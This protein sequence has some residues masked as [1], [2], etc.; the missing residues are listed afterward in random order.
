[1][2]KKIVVMLMIITVLALAF[3]L[4][5][6][7]KE[8]ELKIERITVEYNK[9]VAYRVGSR[10]SSSDFTVTAHL[11][12]DTKEEIANNL[13]WHTESLQL[14]EDG[15]FTVAGE[16]ILKVDFLKYKNLEVKVTV[17]A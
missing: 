6:C 13:I 15:E 9:K 4:A 11:S 10:F 16:F 3:T 5:A 1:M 7:N 2:K 14:N 17:G 12:D 8:D